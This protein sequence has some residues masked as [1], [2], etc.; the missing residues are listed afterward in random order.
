MCRYF[1]VMA[2][3]EGIF[4]AIPRRKK[5]GNPFWL[6][7]PIFDTKCT[8]ICQTI[9]QKSRAK[10]MNMSLIYLVQI[11]YINYFVK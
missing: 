5:N 8:W 1:D 4:C 9:Y 10:L 7:N 11:V 2:S 3:K 6:F